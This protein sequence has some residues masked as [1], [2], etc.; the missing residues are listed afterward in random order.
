[1]SIDKP[2]AEVIPALL[3]PS[4]DFA[5][6]LGVHA[7]TVD[8]PLNKLAQAMQVYS[9]APDEELVKVVG[10][11][12][13]K[14]RTVVRVNG[15]AHATTEELVHGVAATERV[16]PKISLELGLSST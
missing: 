15:A 3:P 13:P 14:E 2:V 1:M 12:G 5:P 11:L 9:G 16:R 4:L 10:Q 8:A 6:A 7:R